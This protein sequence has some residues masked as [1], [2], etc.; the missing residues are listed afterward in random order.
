LKETQTLGSEAIITGA[1]GNGGMSWY[2]DILSQ[3]ISHIWNQLGWHKLSRLVVNR[4]KE[5][6][7]LALPF[8][9]VAKIKMQRIGNQF[10]KYGSAINLE[11]AQRLRL[12]EQMLHDPCMLPA[13]N[14]KERRLRYFMPGRYIGGAYE[15]EIGARFQ[16]GFRDPTADVRVLEFSCSVPDKIFID[17]K[18]GVDRWLIREAMTGRLPNSVRLNNNLGVQAADMV[19][20]LRSCANEVE[21]VL[22]EIM[23]GPA[24]EYVD[25][26]YMRAVWKIIQTEDTNEA[27]VKSITV[28]TRGIMAGLFVNQFYE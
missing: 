13:R 7:L 4:L 8:E 6:I 14:P 12:A 16:L 18:T 10:F 15:A 21:D 1:L 17:P 23:R 11:F 3:P 22:N 26:P 28:L 9:L 25:V 19:P 2:G 20:R 27:F 24:S 5:K